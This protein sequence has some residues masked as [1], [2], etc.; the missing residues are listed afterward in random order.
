MAR[1]RT[2]EDLVADVRKRTNMEDS[3][4]VTDDEILE[5]LNQEGAELRA[6]IRR[7]EGHPHKR[8]SFTLAVTAG[9]SLYPIPVHITDFWELQNIEASIGGISRTLEPYMQNERGALVNSQVYVYSTSPMY[10]MSGD[11]IEF[12]PATENFTAT[13]FYTPCEKR[14]ELGKVPPDKVEGY[15]GYE[16]AMV[17]GASA[18]VL[19]KEESDP[20]FYLGQKERIMRHIDANA[21]Q[22]DGGHPERVTDATGGLWATLYP[23]E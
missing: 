17:Y 23:W 16:I 4:F 7:A 8:E 22:R 2:A 21:A 18:T 15:N 13:V 10:R 1:T 3:E 11:N 9:Q 5:Y 20:S 14:L 12:L 6:R 19:Q